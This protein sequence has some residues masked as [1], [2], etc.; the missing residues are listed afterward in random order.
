HGAAG[1]VG[2]AE[3]PPMNN[4]V[5]LNNDQRHAGYAHLPLVALQESIDFHKVY[6]WWSR[7]PDHR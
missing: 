2:P 4:L 7:V 3:A 1:L 5:S 6:L